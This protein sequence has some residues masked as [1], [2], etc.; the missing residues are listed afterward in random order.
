[1]NINGDERKKRKNKKGKQL[2]N[3]VSNSPLKYQLINF[4]YGEKAVAKT[5][6]SQRRKTADRAPA[7][8]QTDRQTH[9]QSLLPSRSFARSGTR[10]AWSDMLPKV[11]ALDGRGEELVPSLWRG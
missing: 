9:D 10:R 2:P 1:M 6:A 8:R 5:R 7:D 4:A 11:G 3:N